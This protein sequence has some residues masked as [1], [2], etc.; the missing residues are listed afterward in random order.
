MFRPKAGAR[1]IHKNDTINFFRPY[2]TIFGQDDQKLV[3]S[4]IQT[5]MFYVVREKY[6]VECA[7]VNNFVSPC[8]SLFYHKLVTFLCEYVLKRQSKFCSLRPKVYNIKSYFQS[9]RTNK[10]LNVKFKLNLAPTNSKNQ[11]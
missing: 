9:V 5:N 7:F 6:T 1:I 10:K 8:V 11:C 3:I 4:V 2:V